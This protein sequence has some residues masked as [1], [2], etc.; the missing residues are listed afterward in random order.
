MQTAS[1]DRET[2]NL[3]QIGCLYCHSNIT[4]PSFI[5]SSQ[6]SNA[7]CTFED[8]SSQIGNVLDYESMQTDKCH[9]SIVQ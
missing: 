3:V 5:K 9:H 6:I 4:C 1:T 8:H 2:D 7:E